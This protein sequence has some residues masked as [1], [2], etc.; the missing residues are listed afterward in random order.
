MALFGGMDGQLGQPQQPQAQAPAA[1][2]GA[3]PHTVVAMANQM[4][5]MQ[6]ELVQL[7]AELAELRDRRTVMD[8]VVRRDDQ[9]KIAG[10]SIIQAQR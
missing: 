3:P 7:R 2:G 1:P 8:F 6:Q 5:A 9:G 10:A 4:A